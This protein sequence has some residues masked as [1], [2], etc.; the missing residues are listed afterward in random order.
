MSTSP[1][2][3]VIVGAGLAGAKAAE[4]LREDGFD[5]RLILIGDEPERPYER[6]PLSKDYL[7]GE[8]DGVPYVHPEGFLCGCQRDAPTPLYKRQQQ[9]CRGGQRRRKTEPAHSIARTR[10]VAKLGHRRHAEHDSEH[11]TT[12]QECG[13]L[14]CPTE[15]RPM[16]ADARLLPIMAT[17][18][19]AGR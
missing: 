4:T 15:Q 12:K 11:E 6:P 7:R 16:P 3:F 17:V 9:S 8:A 13:H 10:L 5:G 19:G 2:T 14:E 18:Y 1:E